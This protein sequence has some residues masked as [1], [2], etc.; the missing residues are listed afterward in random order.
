[1][2]FL[3]LIIAYIS[4]QETFVH[5]NGYNIFKTCLLV[6]ILLVYLFLHI[7]VQE[8]C[9]SPISLLP[10]FPYLPKALATL[11]MDRSHSGYCWTEALFNHIC[12]AGKRESCEE[13]HEIVMGILNSSAWAIQKKNE[14]FVLL[15]KNPRECKKNIML[16]EAILAA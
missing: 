3:S 5:L 2:D 7:I 8:D 14:R 12:M 4:K 11:C 16:N 9:I 6:F 13:K 10:Q 1:M 15:K